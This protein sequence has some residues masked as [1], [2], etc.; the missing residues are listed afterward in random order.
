MKIKSISVGILTTC[1]FLEPPLRR[2]F[3]LLGETG[4]L[5]WPSQTESFEPPFLLMRQSHLVQVGCPT[6]VVVEVGK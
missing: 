1:V 5:L 6:W 4:R 3:S 2:G